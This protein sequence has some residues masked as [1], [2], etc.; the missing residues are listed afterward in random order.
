MKGNL[1]VQ[2]KT[3][4]SICGF[5][6]NVDSDGWFDLVVKCEQLFLR[7]IY[8]FN[9]LK[10]MDIKTE[11][12]YSE[13]LNR[14]LEFDPLLEK[15][16]DDGDVSDEVSTFLVEDLNDCYLMLLERKDDIQNVSLPKKKFCAKKPINF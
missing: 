2:S 12:K 1:I 15:A 3:M 14:L 6:L 4:C 13:I 16:L 7:N 10:E 5:L 9:D 11:E 8:T